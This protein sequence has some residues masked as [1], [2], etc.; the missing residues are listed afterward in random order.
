MNGEHQYAFEKYLESWDKIKHLHFSELK[1]I[2]VISK[3]LGI[4]EWCIGEIFEFKKVDKLSFRELCKLRR[5]KD[6][7][8]LYDLHFNQKMSLNDIYRL[9]GYSPLYI[10]RVFEDEGLKHLGFVNQLK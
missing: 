6:F 1:T 7:K 5:S 8:F 3:E 9:H 4:P 10:K 2:G